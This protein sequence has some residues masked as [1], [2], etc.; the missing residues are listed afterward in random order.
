MTTDSLL[1]ETG[2]S[3]ADKVRFLASRQAYAGR[4]AEVTARETHM[5]WVFLA[6]D[7]AFK[8]KKPVRFPYL[9]FSTLARREA[10]CRAEFR[11]N[12]RLAA[13]VYR[14]VVPLVR[15]TAGLS[16]GG[17]GEIVDWLVRMRRLDEAEVLEMRLQNHVRNGELDGVAATLARFY[18]HASPVRISAAAY[19]VRW[20]KALA[21]NRQ[22][23]LDA[24]CGLPRG[25]VR[26]IDKELRA[27][28]ARDA[29]LL[30]QRARQRRILDTH[31]DLRPE[32]IWIER[33]V[34]IIDCL[35][36]SATLR[37]ND[38][39]DEIAFLDMECA[40]LG[41]AYAG[42]RIRTRVLA[43]L[44]ERQPEPLYSFYRCHSAMLRARL[45]IAHLLEPNPRS[46][47]K[48]PVL[49]RAYLA[50][51]QRDA[52]RIARWLRRP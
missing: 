7:Q 8:L 9:D 46:P 40:R 24:R 51:A 49:A 21:T 20:S 35:E 48:W 12:R 34:Q 2:P 26:Q 11:L 32:H 37:A 1:P 29:R 13:G 15:G 30:G 10:A 50:L 36:F 4:A 6:G 52:V 44:N 19:L 31:G 28:L 25:I 43:A 18:R 27:F 33:P 41:A 17:P 23:L 22:V 3:L 16:I 14:D 5:S 42:R 38:P 45:V 39:L 47:E